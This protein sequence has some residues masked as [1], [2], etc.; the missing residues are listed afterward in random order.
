MP[1]V[2]QSCPE[3]GGQVVLAD[4]GNI[5]R[6]LKCCREY[7]SE[8]IP[9]S[10]ITI[11]EPTIH[12][13][14]EEELEDVDHLLRTGRLS[15]NDAAAL[16]E[17]IR[18]R[19]SVTPPTSEEQFLH[20]LHQHGV[21]TTEGVEEIAKELVVLPEQGPFKNG[22]VTAGWYSSH[23]TTLKRNLNRSSLKLESVRRT[24][25]R[26]QDAFIVI[27]RLLRLILVMFAV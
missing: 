26:L 11:G 14:L 9:H 5:R 21:I 17:R 16:K 25:I 13:T 27:S 15:H 18:K 1:N 8:G 2:A 24:P 19:R 20:Q 12:K 6:C 10:G 7:T 22:S 4:Y 3:C 23:Q